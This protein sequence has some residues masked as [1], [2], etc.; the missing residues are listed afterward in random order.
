M[1][2][3]AKGYPKDIEARIFYALAL[4]NSDPPDDVDLINPKKAVDPNALL[5]AGQAAERVGDRKLAAQYYRALL[6]NCPCA[7]QQAAR[8]LDHARAFVNGTANL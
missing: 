5:G 7:S 1:E 4:I 6:A 2:A 8:A 3:V